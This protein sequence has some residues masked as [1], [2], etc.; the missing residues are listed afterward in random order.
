MPDLPGDH[1]ELDLAAGQELDEWLEGTS[2]MVHLA[3]RSGGIQFQQEAD[4][5]IFDKNRCM[6]QALLSA[7]SRSQTVS[8][9]FAVSSAAIYARS[10]TPL[11]E[12]AP[13]LQSGRHPVQGRGALRRERN[14]DAFTFK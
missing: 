8:R 10:Q 13:L 12:D 11:G 7:V 5:E 6:T 3:A 4:E 1:V 14:P 9:I 2:S